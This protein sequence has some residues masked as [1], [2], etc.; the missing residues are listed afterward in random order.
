[1]IRANSCTVPNY[2]PTECAERSMNWSQREATTP[3]AKSR[4]GHYILSHRIAKSRYWVES[5]IAVALALAGLSIGEAAHGQQAPSD[6]EICGLFRDFA[7][8]AMI[9]RLGGVPMPDYL[10]SLGPSVDDP[11]AGPLVREIVLQAWEYP[12][13]A[14]TDRADAVIR[15]FADRHM[16][17]CYRRQQGLR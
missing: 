17:A 13:V 2:T 11:E 10:K 16:V 4:F 5:L 15:E 9:V 7:E 6:D 8:N 14:A 1:M 3:N 12:A